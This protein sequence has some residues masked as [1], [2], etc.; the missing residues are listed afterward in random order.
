LEQFHII[1][2]KPARYGEDGYPVRWK[3]P[4]FSSSVLSCLY[5]LADNCRRHR[6]IGEQT[7]IVLHAYDESYQV[8]DIAGLLQKIKN[9]GKA[10]VG[11]VGVQ[12]NQ[13][14]R[15]V[16][17]A[18]P[19]LEHDIPVCIGGF[20]VSGCMAILSELPE[21]IKQAQAMGISLFAGEA[22]QGRF[23]QV[24]RDAYKGQL[25]PVYNFI[26]ELPAIENQPV[27]VLPPTQVKHF[28][29]EKHENNV[30]FDLGR[31]CPFEC[32]FCSVINVHG[33]KNRFRSADDLEQ[34]VRP[35]YKAGIN[36]L[37]ISDDNFSRNKNWE[38]LFDRLIALRKRENIKFSIVLQVDMLSHKNPLFIEKAVKAGVNQLFIGLETINAQNLASMKKRQ[39]NIH[40]YRKMLLAWKKYPVIIMAG[41]IIGLPADTKQSI[42][43]DIETIKR[44][45]PVDLLTFSYLTPLPG[46]MDHKKMIER[47]EWI[48]SDMNK[49]DLTHRVMNHPIMTD[50]EWEETYQEAWEIYYTSEHMNTVLK[51]AASLG[52]DLKLT[53]ATLLLIAKYNNRYFGIQTFDGTLARIRHRN[54]R[55]PGLP[56]ESFLLFHYRNL[57]E[58]LIAKVGISY[59]YFRFWLFVR[60]LWKDSER[61]AYNDRAISSSPLDS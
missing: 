14:P 5:G 34:I 38:K 7:D 28:M 60:R 30:S 33:R 52:S 8:V 2:I 12:S 50:R 16:D 47:G 10:F 26:N 51:R 1:L 56:R 53:T 27:P 19:F 29:V 21:D 9:D 48:D 13:F 22:E 35:I 39:N 59:H 37:F 46:S 57:K 49:Y 40:D 45:L 4:V 31:G 43:R 42:L 20:H 23:D 54:E 58:H 6:I 11:F 15:A 32:S 24:L 61:F 3:L 18:R 44:E 41:F 17:L 55:R 36:R 25:Q